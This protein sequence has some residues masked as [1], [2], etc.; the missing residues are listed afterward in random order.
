MTTK[1]GTKAK[2]IHSQ[3]SVAVDMII[4]TSLVRKTLDNVTCVLIAFENMEKLFP[5]IEGSPMKRR[6]ES[7]VESY[8][9][10]N[11]EIIQ[12]QIPLT[13]K[14]KLFKNSILEDNKESKEFISKMGDSNNINTNQEKSSP[15]IK[16]YIFN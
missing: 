8:D 15:V 16:G 6:V 11:S 4:K 5:F 9:K 3:C 1:E 14:N 13:T 7:S 2:S 12:K 10:I